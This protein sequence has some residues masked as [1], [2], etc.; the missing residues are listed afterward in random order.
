MHSSGNEGLSRLR[1][2]AAA[3]AGAVGGVVEGG[4]GRLA[5]LFIALIAP[6]C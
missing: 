4:G 1:H 5:V 6:S 2:G 3:G